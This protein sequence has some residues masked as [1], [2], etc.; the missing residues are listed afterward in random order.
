[1]D[2]AEKRKRREK[3]QAFIQAGSAASAPPPPGSAPPRRKPKPKKH[4]AYYLERELI[5]KIRI[6]AA[7]QGIQPCHLIERAMGRYLSEKPENNGKG[8]DSK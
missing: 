7:K 2:F 4:V 5:G 1:M 6:E 3:A 8:G